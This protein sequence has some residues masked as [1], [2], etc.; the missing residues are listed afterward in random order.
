MRTIFLIPRIFE[1]SFVFV[2][3]AVL[4]SEMPIF[5]L[6]KSRSYVYGSKE[7]LNPTVAIDIGGTPGTANLSII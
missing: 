4:V 6:A 1:V 7:S 2:G 5:Y 3:V